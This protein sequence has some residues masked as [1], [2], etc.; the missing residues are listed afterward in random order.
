MPY[1]L[2]PILFLIAAALFLLAMFHAGLPFDVIPAG[3]L[4]AALGL[5]A[6]HHHWHPT[7]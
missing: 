4:V 7:A 1:W 6:D 5:A 2:A 3:L